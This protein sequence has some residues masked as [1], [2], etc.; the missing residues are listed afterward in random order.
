MS[1]QKSLLALT[2]LVVITLVGCREPVG[3]T[4]DRV[5][6]ATVEMESCY[7][8]GN[9]Y[10]GHV[11]WYQGFFGRLWDHYG[12]GF[13]LTRAHN[14][15][16]ISPPT[17]AWPHKEGFCIFTVP[18]F[19]ASGGVVACTLY[20]YQTSHSGTASLLAVIGFRYVIR[21]ESTL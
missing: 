19:E 14:W 15:Y 7:V 16:P 9:T 8:T 2:A 13:T 6:A 20:Y 12:F 5:R 18:H 17:I 10:C 1:R 11:D 4:N 3:L 21:R